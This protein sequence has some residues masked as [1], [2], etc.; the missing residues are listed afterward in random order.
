MSDW[1]KTFPQIFDDSPAVR[2]C[3]RSVEKAGFE[4]GLQVAAQTAASYALEDPTQDSIC[5]EIARE[6]SA[7]GSGF[8]E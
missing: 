2:A 3:L 1:I 8:M 6:I 7:A 4:K 5:R